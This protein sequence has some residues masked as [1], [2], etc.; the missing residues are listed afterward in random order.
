MALLSAELFCEVSPEPVLA[1]QVAVE[2]EAEPTVF[3]GLDETENAFEAAEPEAA[4]PE[5]AEPEE[6]EPAA[7]P[8]AEPES[9][10]PGAEPE[11]EPQVEA[12]AMAEPEAEVEPLLVEPIATPE[13]LEQRFDLNDA[14]AN[15]LGVVGLVYALIFSQ[16]Y[17]D[18]QQRLREI[19]D[20]LSSEAGGIHICMNLVRVLDDKSHSAK[21]KVLLLLSSYVEDLA[22]HIDD[23]SGRPA[24]EQDGDYM[25][26]ES[27]YSCVPV[28]AAICNDSD[29]DGDDVIDR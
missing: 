4:E 15:F 21:I 20:S 25:P 22:S 16:Q 11:A 1:E 9:A 6:A 19:Q 2:P 5:A 14:I 12:T 10:G 29:G 23:L 17:A 28:L 18:A 3:A 13:F 8:A 24:L 27:L 26:L 7:E